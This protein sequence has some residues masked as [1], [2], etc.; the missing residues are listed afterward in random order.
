MCGNF[1]GKKSNEYEGPQKE[2][3]KSQKSFVYKYLQPNEQC[4][5]DKIQQM[6]SSSQQSSP[7]S[8]G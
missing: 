6:K 4:S 2:Q 5:S 1:D 8:P 3:H 7:S